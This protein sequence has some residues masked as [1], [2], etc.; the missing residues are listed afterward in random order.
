M[1]PYQ[2]FLEEKELKMKEESREYRMK[3]KNHLE[4]SIKMIIDKYPS[5]IK[6]ILFGSYVDGGFTS[7]PTS[8]YIFRV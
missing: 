4:N 3:I 1:N 7:F 6:V 8:I 2:R 5:I